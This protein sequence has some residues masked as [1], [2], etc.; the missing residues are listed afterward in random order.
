MNEGKLAHNQ[1][2]SLSN[3]FRAAGNARAELLSQCSVSQSRISAMHHYARTI[4]CRR[5]SNF[6]DLDIVL[7]DYTTTTK[8]SCCRHSAIG[9]FVARLPSLRHLATPAYIGHPPELG[10]T[11][12]RRPRR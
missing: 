3:I 1:F 5:V 10:R 7:A 8:Y 12:V 11:A 6:A 9:P 2:N 4:Y